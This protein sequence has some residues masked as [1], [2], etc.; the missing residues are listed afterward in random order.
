[1][2][3][4]TFEKAMKQLEQIVSELETGDLPLE[5]AI[6]KFEEGVKLSRYCS[7][8]LDSTEKRAMMLLKKDDG[9]VIEQPFFP[10][11]DLPS[12]PKVS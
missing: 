10:Q 12:E 6:K 1:M 8:A 11:A 3:T 7:E 2:A 9:T 4:Q 5:K